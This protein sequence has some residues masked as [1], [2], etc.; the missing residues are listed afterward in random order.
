MRHRAGLA[1]ATLIGSL[2][3]AAAPAAANFHLMQIEQVVGGLCGDPASQ[4]IQLRMRALGQNEVSGHE[5]VA[6]DHNGEN[7]VSL[8]VFPADVANGAL[9]DRILLATTAFATDTGITPDFVLGQRIP[10]E[11][12][13]AGRVTF[14]SAANSILWSLAWGGS[15][16]LGT[17][18]GATTN[19]ADGDF[20]AP[21]GQRL[22][23]NA[24]RSVRFTGAA[25]ALS[26]DNAADYQLTSGPATVTNNGGQSVVLPA[27]CIFGDGFILGDVFDWSDFAAVELCNGIDDDGDTLIDEDFPLGQA[28]LLPGSTAGTLTCAPDGQGTICV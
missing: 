19:D 21:V 3:W 2:A 15:Y 12:L 18:S 1:A 11:Y 25:T 16:W 13:R 10:D 20:G 24:T 5:V 17:N 8:L 4:A 26:T 22:A 27:A 9:G 28:C 6:Y 23:H 14:E 7:P